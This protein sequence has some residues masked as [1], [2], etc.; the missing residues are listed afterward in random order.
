MPGCFSAGDTF[1]EALDCVKEAIDVPLEGLAEQGDE[2]PVPRPIQEHRA[3]HD[4]D[5]RLR[6]SSR[7]HSQRLT[8]RGGAARHE[9]PRLGTRTQTARS[10]PPI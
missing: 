8:G 2:V 5:R 7:R 10:L 3:N 4:I 1:E 9:R 6:E